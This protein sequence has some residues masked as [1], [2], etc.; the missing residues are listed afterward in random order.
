[1]Q[2]FLVGLLLFTL[3]SVAYAAD[4]LV[5]NA[6][7]YAPGDPITI[8]LTTS[9][10]Y[11]SIV[12]SVNGSI[13]ASLTDT[14]NGF[15]GSI[16][17]TG[18][19]TCFLVI[20]GLIP[21]TL[22]IKS[23]GTIIH[24]PT[25]ISTTINRAST[26]A[27]GQCG[28]YFV[29]PPTDPAQ[30]QA[31]TSTP[32][33]IETNVPFNE[34]YITLNGKFFCNIGQV[35]IGSPGQSVTA[36][37]SGYVPCFLPFCAKFAIVGRVTG[38]SLITYPGPVVQLT[39]NPACNAT[40]ITEPE[41]APGCPNPYSPLTVVTFKIKINPNDNPAEY[42]DFEIW[43]SSSVPGIP[44]EIFIARTSGPLCE[45]DGPTTYLIAKW[46]IPCSL[47]NAGVLVFI[48]S[49]SKTLDGSEKLLQFL[50]S[51]PI[52]IGS[53]I[54]CNLSLVLNFPGNCPL[55]Y[56]PVDCGC[57]AEGNGTSLVPCGDCP[58]CPR[59]GIRS[60]DP[61]I[62]GSTLN[63]YVHNGSIPSSPTNQSGI[64]ANFT[65]YSN[66]D[67]YGYAF[68]PNFFY[69][70]D[71][72]TP[73]GAVGYKPYNVVGNATT[74]IPVTPPV[75][76]NSITAFPTVS[77]EYIWGI[78]SGTFQLFCGTQ[79]SIAQANV[80]G[81]TPL[82]ASSIV[83]SGPTGIWVTD[84]IGRLYYSAT[85]QCAPS[86]S[87][88]PAGA[89]NVLHMA[90]SKTGVYY[91]TAVF[92]FHL[93]P[94][95][96][97][98]LPV[99][100]GGPTSVKSLSASNIDDSLV[101]VD[102]SNSIWI[103]SGPTGT[104]THTNLVYPFAVDYDINDLFVLL[105]FSG[106]SNV[107]HIQFGLLPFY[108]VIPTYLDLSLVITS[109]LPPLTLSSLPVAPVFDSC[110]NSLLAQWTIPASFQGA[111]AA[112]ATLNYNAFFPNGTVQNLTSKATFFIGPSPINPLLPRQ[113]CPPPC[114][115]F[116][117]FPP[118]KN[119]GCSNCH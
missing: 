54:Q 87:F 114:H 72:T 44:S 55:P 9:N 17:F 61:I 1:M 6:A 42:R 113:F 115:P 96:A 66:I 73:N 23:D 24:T 98:P 97:P 62:P 107:N 63:F 32:V 89:T 93:V 38:G 118:P 58:A 106:T 18:K 116:K 7:S 33:T 47:N 105:P 50:Q 26:L 99:P 53:N 110:N 2:P 80:T 86:V 43:A 70:S 65:Y 28:V 84:S 15:T 51:A 101:V 49:Y 76:L 12:I 34:S 8:T 68:S 94:P 85:V 16:T 103:L 108:N 57:L 90:S 117:C 41:T 40:F 21:N 60:K 92:T 112:T 109:N 25:V 78:S 71:V 11:S 22:V 102:N 5:T 13:F 56:D 91:T 46:V 74:P 119:P 20:S 79:A 45:L 4:T 10:V 100:G 39:P 67:L 64:V 36:G 37:C 30:I 14:S 52:T 75:Q 35:I 19:I 88:I 48:L 3:W 83:A 82:G 95:P 59:L 69:F 77:T 31:G 27:P 111:G 29:N 104:W 81:L